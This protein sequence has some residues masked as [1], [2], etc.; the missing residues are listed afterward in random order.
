MDVAI[1]VPTEELNS[2]T[3]HA[4]WDEIFD[5]LA[6]YT[7]THR[8]T[9]VFVNT[10]KMVER[11]SF[12]LAERLG[13]EN[14]A[15]HHGSLSRTLRL[16]AERRLKRGEIKILVATASLEL[17]IDI[18]N[19]DL[20]CQIASTRSISVA[21]QRV[22]R[23]GH[24]RGAIPRGRLFA[25]TRDDLIEQ[26][27]LVRKM[28]SGEFDRLEIPPQPVDVLMQQIVAACGAEPW[29]KMSLFRVLRRAYPYKDLSIEQY[30]ELIAMLANGIES[31]RGR[32]GAYLVHD[33]IHGELHPRRG[34]R[35]IAISNGG[36]IPDTALFNVILQP[37]ELQIA[38]L[39]EHF[40]VDSSPGDVIHLGNSS[41]RVQRIDPAGKVHVEDAHGAPPSIPF[42][43]GEAPQRTD[44]VSDGVCELRQE[45]S[46]RLLNISPE[47]L[48]PA[49]PEIASTAAWLM[50]ECGI[51]NW[52]AQ[53]FIAYIV[54]GRAV[55]GAVPTK[56]AVIAERFF[57]EGGGMQL[58]L[59]VPF[60][61]RINKAWGLA[62]RKRFCRGFNFELQA[63]ATD[64]GINIS[65]AEQ[66]SFP[67]SD[68]FQFLT[69]ITVTSLLEQ[70]SLAAPV[71]K[72]QWRWAAGRSLQL[73]RFSNG[74]RIA[75]QVQRTRSEDLLASVFPQA[76][77]CFENIEGDIQ[78][79]D[80][81]L[82]REVMQ[83]VLQEAMDLNGL[84]TVLRGIQD[85]SIRCLAVD[86]P[87]PS[88]FAHE[89][90]NANPYAFLDE[91]G[92]EERRARAV[93]L[94]TGIPSTIIERPGKL[95][96]TAIATVRG[97]CWPDVRDHH[98]LHDL[99]MSVVVLP[100]SMLDDERTP[101]WA[102]FHHRLESRGRA[103]TISYCEMPCWIATERL[104]MVNALWNGIADSGEVRDQALRKCVQGWVQLLGPVTATR[105]GRQFSLDP[106][107]VLQAFIALEVQGLLMRGSYEHPPVT[108][109]LEVE[110][111][112]RRI[113]QRIHK[114]TIGARRK[115]I[116]PVAS[117][118][119]MQWLLGWQ[120]IAPQTQLS[121]EEG[122]LEAISKLEGFEA[123]A[124]EWEKMIFPARIANY[125][126]RWLDHLCLSGSV[127]WGRVSPHP[128]FHESN[129]NGPRRVTPTG[130]AP[131]TFYL[132]DSAAWM[133]LAL[134][135]HC[136]AEEKLAQALTPNALRVLEL[137]RNKG[138]CFAEEIQ[139]FSHLASIQV[140]HALWE[141]A[142]AGLTAADGFD[143]LRAM[144][145]PN[146]RVTSQ[147][148]YRK[149]RSS[150]G[151]W[152]LFRADAPIPADHIEAARFE[153]ASVDSAARMLLW[154]YGVVFRN[155]L[156]LESNLPR[157]GIL[158][159]M[160][161]RLEDRGEIRGGRFVRNFS[162]EQF[163]LPDVAESLQAVVQQKAEFETQLAGADP[164]N[165]VGILIPGE[166]VPASIGRTFVLRTRDLEQTESAAIQKFHAR[167]RL[168]PVYSPSESQTGNSST[169]FI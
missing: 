152:S 102:E 77:A 144:I 30:E 68:V 101:H 57:D 139:R 41:W 133:D 6:A 105:F 111:C 42:W 95:D 44:V 82:V 115:Q 154:R 26:A 112:E 93:S 67:L 62:L 134:R 90:I 4:M 11:V 33:G 135:D 150:A 168:S 2:I 24:W 96:P 9:L 113:L 106:K 146:R 49:Q 32:Y 127:G 107:I 83:D 79:P 63:A 38:T 117:S 3:S 47:F 125:D 132:R 149:T 121:G 64:N 163:A 66:H 72:T 69:D 36:A 114:F 29:D 118:T 91:A 46:Q 34:A 70:A 130:A 87:V 55:L 145:D 147:T 45:I 153:D 88:Q 162:G 129:G 78:I 71:F 48:S 110:W 140:E 54:A 164:L 31:S 74:K 104:S 160:L 84:L 28:R 53:Q 76:A 141:L 13:V 50:E 43:T 35:M 99:L 61:G 56:S 103:Q 161:R 1:E 89:L 59:H 40:A 100:L 25:T 165:L 10:R 143:Q 119:F 108:D 73:L 92:L 123:P 157:W 80:H 75:P 155:L 15:A 17:G 23:A 169:L 14:V 124:A 116:E 159:R 18:G 16:D 5:K 120:H 21:M 166:R 86:T 167:K 85:G 158:L 39:D 94:K 126:P 7:E 12:A 109:E 97:Q 65:L 137:M 148:W 58:I 151:R 122:L 136:V 138:A 20:V 98:E 27:A 142:A 51:S 37:D 22:G 19:V 128:A 52:G 8:S 131:I 156:A 60:G 81:P